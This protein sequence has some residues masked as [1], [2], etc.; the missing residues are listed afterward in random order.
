MQEGRLTGF[1]ELVDV[2]AISQRGANRSRVILLDG[3]V[4]RR[5]GDARHTR[6]AEGDDQEARAA[7]A[8]ELSIPNVKHC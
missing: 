7:H 1:G 2:G 3:S 6:E 4:Q 8:R 5:C